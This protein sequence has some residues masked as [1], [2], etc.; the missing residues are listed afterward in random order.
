MVKGAFH[1]LLVTLVAMILNRDQ[2]RAG[3]LEAA[4]FEPN[5]WIAPQWG[6]ILIFFVLL[7]AALGAVA[8]MVVAL[9][10]G[11]GAEESAS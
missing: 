10:K 7:V 5:T 4:G 3:A 2:V 11:K 9:A 8:W 6:P 1:C